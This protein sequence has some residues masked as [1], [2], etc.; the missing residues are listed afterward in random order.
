MR[1]RAGLDPD[2]ARRQCA[3][4]GLDFLAAEP[5]AQ[6]GATVRRR[7]VNLED[8][9]CD[10]EPDKGDVVGM[11]CSFLSANALAVCPSG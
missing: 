1:T 9:L 3:E 6:D 8:R 4:E 2:P 5:T 11:K 10:V 7:T